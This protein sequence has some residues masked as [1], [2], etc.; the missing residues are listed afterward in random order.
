MRR[1]TC[2][3]R[4][5]RGHC[6][7]RAT[8]IHR[9]LLLVLLPRGI[10]RHHRCP[11]TTCE[12]REGE[13]GGGGPTFLCKRVPG[14][15]ASEWSSRQHISRAV[16][17]WVGSSHVAGVIRDVAGLRL[18]VDHAPFAAGGIIEPTKGWSNV[19]GSRSGPDCCLPR[20]QARATS[21]CQPRS[22]T[23]ERTDCSA[24]PADHT[25]R[26]AR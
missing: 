11:T 7:G 25:R 3:R 21:C 9:G 4:T 14:D 10:C 2:I 24:V 1:L 5:D 19:E 13:R 20:R 17:L 6:A 26:G 12:R 8:T 22:T 15:G 16:A 23:V 18:A